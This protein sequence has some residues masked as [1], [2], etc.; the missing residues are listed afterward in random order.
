M[1]TLEDELVG[2]RAQ[3]ERFS[4]R[5]SECV[6]VSGWVA[7]FIGF[8]R[9]LSCLVNAVL[10]FSLLIKRYYCATLLLVRGDSLAGINA[11]TAS[12]HEMYAVLDTHSKLLNHSV[13]GCLNNL[14][15]LVSHPV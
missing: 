8:F 1:S 5:V 13:S 7:R 4:L 12:Y 14:V 3:L 11:E 15:V 10:V 6:V 2:L 9:A